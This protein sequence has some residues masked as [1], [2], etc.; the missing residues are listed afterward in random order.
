MRHLLTYQYLEA[1][2]RAGSIRKA[3][4]TLAITST[5]LNRRI[6]ALEQELGEELFE[7]LPKGVRL[8]TAGEVFYHF[9]RSQL[10]DF[11]R[12]KSHIA[13]LQG[14]RRGHVSIAC[15]QAMLTS[16]L[17]KEIAFYRKQHPAVTFEVQVRDRSAAEQAL[18]DVSADLAL[19]FEP[20]QLADF[21]VIY[22]V[23]QPVYALLPTDHPLA[24]FP[25]LTLLQCQDYPIALP[26]QAYGVRKLLEMSAR[27]SRGRLRPDVESDSFEFLRYQAIAEGVIT[28]QIEM[29]LPLNLQDNGLVAIRMNQKDV[30]PGILYI[31]QLKGRTLPVAAA[32]FAIQLINSLDKFCT[33]RT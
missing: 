21:Q 10:R 33:Q 17:P 2:V 14:E 24:E 9:A 28:F 19:V 29:G 4:E 12:V 16:Y 15:S 13:D 8:S 11:E 18:L 26:T 3:A 22:S 30:P 32:K 1:I 6:L 23:Q 7:R 5:A 25:E 31:G 27:R 20:V